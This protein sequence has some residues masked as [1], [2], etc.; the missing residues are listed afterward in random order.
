MIRSVVRV[1]LLVLIA[2]GM[3]SV[4]RADRVTVTGHGDK[5]V[6]TVKSGPGGRTAGDKRRIY[7]FHLILHNGTITMHRS[8]DGW[9]GSHQGGQVIWETASAPIRMGDRLSGFAIKIANAT[10]MADWTTTDREGE[11]IQFGVINLNAP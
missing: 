8:P 9:H 10:G 4:A 11:L 6:L 3:A 7:D 5:Y 1:S 2:A